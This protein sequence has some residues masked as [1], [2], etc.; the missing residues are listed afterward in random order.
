MGK[1]VSSRTKNRSKTRTTKKTA[2]TI[3]LLREILAVLATACASFFVFSLS[4][5]APIAKQ[6]CQFIPVLPCG[7]SQNLM[8]PAGKVVGES[9]FGLFGFASVGIAA[10]LIYFSILLWRHADDTQAVAPT[11]ALS[12]IAFFFLSLALLSGVLA[13]S[14]QPITG[15]VVGQ[16]LRRSTESVFGVFGALL[17]HFFTLAIAVKLTVG[18]SLFLMV[19]DIATPFLEVGKFVVLL[20]NNIVRLVVR[21]I[22]AILSF[23]YGLLISAFRALF[24]WFARV[25]SFVGDFISNIVTKRRSVEVE[26]APPLKLQ[27]PEVKKKIYSV[28][29]AISDGSTINDG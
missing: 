14:F 4:S 7:Y 19:Q 22:S 16:I 8:G 21:S 1:R 6:L 17:I 10:F 9:L 20:L 5:L 18:R 28:S 25:V 13:L 11:S 27:K 23:T 24:T 15:G 2:P 29:V 12:R 3:F 26:E